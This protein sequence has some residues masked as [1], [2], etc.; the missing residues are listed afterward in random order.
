MNINLINH[1]VSFSVNFFHITKFSRSQ[2]LEFN[3]FNHLQIHLG[4]SISH[5]DVTQLTMI[6]ND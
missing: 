5:I 2:S 3:I 6:P 4:V 1:F